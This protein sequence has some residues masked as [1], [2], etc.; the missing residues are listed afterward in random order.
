[1]RRSSG[2]ARCCAGR[3]RWRRRSGPGR[4]TRCRGR[5]GGGVV[6]VELNAALVGGDGVVGSGPGRDTRCRGRCG[7][8]TPAGCRPVFGEVQR[9]L[10]RVDGRGVLAVGPT[11]AGQRVEQLGAR[12]QRLAGLRE[13]AQQRL[14]ERDLGRGVLAQCAVIESLPGQIV[15]QGSGLFGRR[16]LHE[17]HDP[18]PEDPEIGRM[19]GQRGRF[20]LGQ[21]ENRPDAIIHEIFAA[22][23]EAAIGQRA[24]PPAAPLQAGNEID[25]RGPVFSRRP[26]AWAHRHPPRPVTR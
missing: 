16:P 12:G 19:P 2:R 15:R 26:G 1:M 3:R 7:S 13:V 23:V 8:T 6:R 5:C 4:D 10:K 11:Q 25:R 14:P 18:V 20:L 17:F 9:L 21:P 24:V 22:D